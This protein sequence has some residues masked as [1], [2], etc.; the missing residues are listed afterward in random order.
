MN[1]FVFLLMTSPA[2]AASVSTWW[3][4]TQGLTVSYHEEQQW[5]SDHSTLKL[6]KAQALENC[7]ETLTQCR[8]EECWERRSGESERVPHDSH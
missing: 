3:C 7:R 5:G 6:A 8:I 1:L 4:S 2:Y